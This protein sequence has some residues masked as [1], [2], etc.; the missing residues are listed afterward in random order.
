MYLSSFV[1]S[2]MVVSI[3]SDP[4]VS[5]IRLSPTFLLPLFVNSDVHVSIVSDHVSCHA[6]VHVKQP[7][8]V[9]RNV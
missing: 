3:V 9:H 5:A 1:N 2:D 4:C 8:G 6:C 7:V